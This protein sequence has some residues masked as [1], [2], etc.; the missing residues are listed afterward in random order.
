[1]CVFFQPFVSFLFQ[2]LF[3]AMLLLFVNILATMYIPQKN[4]ELNSAMN[5]IM[6]L[7]VAFLEDKNS[8][9]KKL[10][11]VYTYNNRRIIEINWIERFYPCTRNW[12]RLS[13]KNISCSMLI[14]LGLLA[15]WKITQQPKLMILIRTVLAILS[16]LYQRWHL[17]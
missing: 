2:L 8:E 4:T 5:E 7:Y 3:S 15:Y 10:S 1:M 12:E 16:L 14:F 11:I 13:N 9:K 17:I 6:L